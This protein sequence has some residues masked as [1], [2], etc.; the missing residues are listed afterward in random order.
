[1][2]AIHVGV[3]Y[4]DGQRTEK[5]LKELHKSL[6]NTELTDLIQLTP[7]D[8]DSRS[9]CIIALP[10]NTPPTDA[11]EM[12]NVILSRFSGSAFYRDNSELQDMSLLLMGNQ[13]AEQV[14]LINGLS[15]V[16]LENSKPLQLAKLTS[17]SFTSSLTSMCR[18]SVRLPDTVLVRSLTST[19]LTKAVDEIQRGRCLYTAKPTSSPVQQIVLKPAYGGGSRG[20]H[21]VDWVRLQQTDQL[22]ECVRACTG[23]GAVEGRAWLVQRCVGTPQKQVR[24][25]VVNSKVIYAVA[26]TKLDNVSNTDD[27]LPWHEAQNLCLCEVSDDVSLSLHSTPAP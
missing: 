1:M 24:L 5:L 8:L 16:Q 13:D 2:P 19:G 25:E 4:E 21:L 12:V 11:S 15:V 10:V 6:K 26:I 9:N 7:L 3:V 23:V 27:D 18:D 22:G 20:V 17:A 14:G